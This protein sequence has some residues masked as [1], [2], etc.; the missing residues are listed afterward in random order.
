MHHQEMVRDTLLSSKGMKPNGG[1]ITWPMVYYTIVI[2]YTMILYYNNIITYYNLTL[3]L[4]PKK[5]ENKISHA[6]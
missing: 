6:F 2:Y 4:N 5:K 1:M 3:Q